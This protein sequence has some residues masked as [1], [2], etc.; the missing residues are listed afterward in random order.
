MQHFVNDDGMNI[1]R[2]PAGWQF[3]VGNNL[4]GNLDSNNF[5]RYNTLVQACLATGAYCILDVHNYARWNGAIVG[6]GGPT[7]AQL[8]SVW[9]Q[10]ASKYASQSK[11]IFGVMNEPHDGESRHS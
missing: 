9:S 6:Q 8:A 10:L 4:G 1:F 3:L 11:I 2:L 7:N 5:N